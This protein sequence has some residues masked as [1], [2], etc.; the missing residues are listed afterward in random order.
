MNK[1]RTFT[2]E[3]TYQA[4]GNVYVVSGANWDGIGSV[5]LT[6]SITGSV[7]INNAAQVG[8]VAIQEIVGSV[9]VNNFVLST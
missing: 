7:H 8:S 5:H 3:Q 2:V 6:N 4:S 1:K 9:A